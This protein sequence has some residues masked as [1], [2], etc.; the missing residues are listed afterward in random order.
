[1]LSAVP[2][3]WFSWDFSLQ[4]PMGEDIAEIQLSSWRERGAVVLRGASYRIHREGFAGPFLVESPDGSPAASAVK[5]SV[6]KREFEIVFG[7]RQYR[8]QAVSAFRR[9]FGLFS[10]TRRIGS[11]T[12][13][14][15]I[16]RRAR[17]EFAEELPPLLQA[18]VL[19]L[20]LL[21]WQRE[22]QDSASGGAGA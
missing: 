5:P 1:M 22:S 4:G 19:W 3:G 7:S 20:T 10:G 14:S 18:F 21:L 12:P 17:V 15:W 11:I 16:G 8:L 13:D 6:L 2:K 9:E